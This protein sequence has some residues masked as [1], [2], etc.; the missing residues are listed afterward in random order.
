MEWCT[1]SRK[2]TIVLVERGSR[3]V[4]L[5]AK[6]TGE[7]EHGGGEVSKV[8][9]DEGDEPRPERRAVSRGAHW[10][11][12]GVVEGAVEG[13]ERVGHAGTLHPA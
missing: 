7:C 2:L 4:G 10:R 3:R 1:F 5:V 6:P 8:G 11:V 13:T 12:E 9:G